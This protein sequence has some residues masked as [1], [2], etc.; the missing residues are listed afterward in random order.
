MK[1]SFVLLFI[2]GLFCLT[3][4]SFAATQGS[5]IAWGYN[6]YNQCTLPSY[7]K[8]DSNFVSV[9]AGEGHS[10]ALREDGTVNAW[11][12]NKYNQAPPVSDANYSAIACGSIFSVVITKDGKV[13][14]RGD[15]SYGESNAPDNNFVYVAISAGNYHALAVRENGSA[16]AW[17]YNGNGQCNIPEPNSNF[18]DVAAGYI[19]SL[20]LKSDG[21]IVAWGDN[22]FGQCNIP[23]PNKDFI[24]IAAGGMHSLGLKVDGSIVAWG[25][26]NDRQ[27]K[28]PKPN[29][30][31]VGIAAGYAH[32]LGLKGDGSIV[33]WGWDLYHQNDVCAPNERFFA[34]SAGFGHSLA[35]RSECNFP[36]RPT[37]VSA[38]DGLY[39]DHIRL[40]WKTVP[41]IHNY[42]VWRGT[43]NNPVIATKLARIFTNSYDDYDITSDSKYY[44]WI[45]AVNSCGD[46]FFSAPNSGY[47]ALNPTINDILIKECTVTAKA[48]NNDSIS[49]SGLINADFNDVNLADIIE[50]NIYSDDLNIPIIQT[51]LVDGNT[52]KNGRFNC[53]KTAGPLKTSFFFDTKTSKFSC[54]LKNIDLSGLA[55]PFNFKITVG[56]FDVVTDIN[57]TIVNGLKKPVPISLLTGIKNSLRV[58]KFNYHPASSN[59]GWLLAKG[60]FSVLNPDVN[61]ADS[62]FVISLSGQAFTI[63]VGSL[64]ET[65]LG[66]ACSNLKLADGSIASVNFNFKTCSFS[67][68][69]R[70]ANITAVTAPA[71]LSIQFADF[72][73]TADVPLP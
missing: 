3:S 53:S 37:G 61:M 17:G 56:G 51:F 70:K 67:L 27:C 21:T 33:A 54:A 30:N 15:N 4:S 47:T 62:N 39:A 35:L 66:Y 71:E 63:P 12:W 42:E 49:I 25:D 34:L 36:A 6:Q 52:F 19:H 38:S 50:V 20:G 45:R 26:N 57:E 65:K 73:E 22:S 1:R 43:V 28:V 40:T 23:S 24:A 29:S 64:K 7:V 68:S 10:V 72:S 46:S 31:F 59:K 14:A 9:A 60:G 5:V 32:S 48:D 55:C 13:Y 18:T 2:F 69:V 11:G 8:Q 44:Y 41:N 16:I 58:D